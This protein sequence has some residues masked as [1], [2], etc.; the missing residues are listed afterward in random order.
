[1]WTEMLQ[2]LQFVLSHTEAPCI[3]NWAQINQ[4]K[5]KKDNIYRL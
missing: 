1:M 2:P 4:L 5:K 3:I